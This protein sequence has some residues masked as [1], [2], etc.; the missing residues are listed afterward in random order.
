MNALLASKA[1]KK[2]VYQLII[3][4]PKDHRIKQDCCEGATWISLSGGLQ[5][6]L[7]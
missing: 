1:T 4:I 6:A 2:H 3:F 7:Q 5:L